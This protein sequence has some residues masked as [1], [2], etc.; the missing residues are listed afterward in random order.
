MV[1]RPEDLIHRLPRLGITRRN[2][3]L[4]YYAVVLATPSLAKWLDPQSPFLE[5]AV[6]HMY[7]ASGAFRPE[8]R[9]IV[10]SAVVDRLP[11]ARTTSTVSNVDRQT[12]FAGYEG[13]AL[14]TSVSD[15]EDP[16]ERALEG[17]EADRGL[18]RFELWPSDSDGH[19]RKTPQTTPITAIDLRLANT[20][21]VNGSV[22]TV[23][24]DVF[25][26]VD[27]DVS[28][29][30]ISFVRR[31][32]GRRQLPFLKISVPTEKLTLDLRLTR[33][34][35]SYEVVS[36]MGNVIRQL[37][38]GSNKD[39][40]PASEELETKIPQ[41][42]A[43]KAPSPGST[44]IFALVWPAAMSHGKR[45]QGIMGAVDTDLDAV[46]LWTLQTTLLSGARLHRVTSGGGGWG[47]K[48]GLLSLD[49]ALD[50]SK[51]EKLAPWD[52][53]SDGDVL[54]KPSIKSGIVRP[55]DY[56]QFF[57]AFVPDHPETFH[58]HALASVR[59]DERTPGPSDELACFV[60]GS[61][62]PPDD[63]KPVLPEGD[64]SRTLIY[65]PNQFGMLSEE[66]TC[67]WTMHLSLVDESKTNE[68]NT[69]P[70]GV[71]SRMDVQTG[72]WKI[73]VG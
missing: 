34:T 71:S 8:D 4:S 28:P 11:G 31:E 69:Q 53:S 15:V 41:Y 25:E 58:D 50:L 10:R 12:S 46:S 40:F 56:V 67:I 55:G 45:S 65:V 59:N 48:Q 30:R 39:P 63:Y 18:V 43:S 72:H 61:V 20:L 9:I 26:N 14:Y 35:E 44:A 66:G 19:L 24:Q 5:K 57:A 17:M 1:Q 73:T 37:T 36:S 3:R 60:L 70:T 2:Q 6:N 27:D 23:F 32:G 13:M 33:L 51:N 38:R 29:F 21:F 47:K 64:E 62:R 52:R 49:P 22:F 54:H 68:M 7:E 42:L 16:F